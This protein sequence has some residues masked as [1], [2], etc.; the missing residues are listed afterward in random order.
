MKATLFSNNFEPW[1]IRE[2]VVHIWRF[3]PFQE[4][5]EELAKVLSKLER[6]RADALPPEPRA[7]FISVH[8]MT[9]GMLA[10]YLLLSPHKIEYRYHFN[11]PAVVGHTIEF[12]HARCGD[13]ALLGISRANRLGV[14]I[15]HADVDPASRLGGR[16]VL[17]DAERVAA[18][19]RRGYLRIFCRKEAGLKATGVGMLP[20]LH[21][22]NVA[23]DKV[24]FSSHLLHIQDLDV[25]SDHVA[26][27]A[28]SSMCAQV[29]AVERETLD[30]TW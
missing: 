24:D 10:R 11:K 17:H 1:P 4:P 21:K 14:D 22:I 13:V 27:L 5:V 28:T 12:N 16:F 9:R 30:I 3:S 15:E 20:E 6:E 25:G 26:A 23:G 18:E 8:A 19:T 29:T 7:A 2:G